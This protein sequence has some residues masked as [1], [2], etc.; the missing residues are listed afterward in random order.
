MP[1]VTVAKLFEDNREALK[2]SWAAGEAHAAEVLDSRLI[3][4]SYGQRFLESLPPARLVH[5]HSAIEGFLD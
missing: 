3:E 4:R 1:Q 2:L 5:D